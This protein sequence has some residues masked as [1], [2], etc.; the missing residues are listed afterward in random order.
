MQAKMTA[1]EQTRVVTWTSSRP[2]TADG[3]I[4]R[5]LL[6]PSLFAPFSCLT[7]IQVKFRLFAQGKCTSP[8][9]G[10][11]SADWTLPAGAGT[12]PPARPNAAGQGGTMPH[13]DPLLSRTI[14][15]SEGASAPIR[16]GEYRG[17]RR[18][19]G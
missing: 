14:L 12:V 19:T 9:A 13:A 6:P 3:P 4:A 1:R 2:R 11:G 17:E 8:P 7:G 18:G 16:A 10:R 5:I 15:I